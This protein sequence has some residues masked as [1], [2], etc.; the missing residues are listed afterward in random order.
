MT[1]SETLVCLRG[2]QGEYVR[3]M[4]TRWGMPL[5]TAARIIVENERQ[6]NG[7]KGT[8]HLGR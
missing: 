3:D 8:N 4:A 7:K 5:S 2:R 1:N 6:R